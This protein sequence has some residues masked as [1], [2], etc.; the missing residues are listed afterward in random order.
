MLPVTVLL[1][2]LPFAFAAPKPQPAAHLNPRFT[3]PPKPSKI[4]PHYPTAP[5]G[6]GSTTGYG[7]SANLSTSPGANDC[8]SPSNGPNDLPFS[9]VVP[10]GQ[11]NSDV[12]AVDG[13]FW[14]G[15]KQGSVCPK[16]V[17][18]DCAKYNSTKTLLKL[19]NGALSLVSS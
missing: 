2:L 10:N 8:G 11:Q 6:T 12:H 16:S 15:R 7:A 13:G 19:E 9:I 4:A 18:G 3:P 1:S 5:T 14:T 17:G